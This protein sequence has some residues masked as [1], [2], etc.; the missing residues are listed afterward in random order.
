MRDNSKC[1]PL[2][3]N[4]ACGFDGGECSDTT[5]HSASTLDSHATS[6]VTDSVYEFRKPQAVSILKSTD[7]PVLQSLQQFSETFINQRNG[8]AGDVSLQTHSDTSVTIPTSI[9]CSRSSARIRDTS[10]SPGK[11]GYGV[12]S[13]ACSGL[14]TCSSCGVCGLCSA[15]GCDSS[16][17][18]S[19][20][21]LQGPNWKCA[22]AVPSAANN[23]SLAACIDTSKVQA[24]GSQ[25]TNDQTLSPYVI[26]GIVIAAIVTLAGMVFV[27]VRVTHTRTLANASSN[28]A[29]A[30]SRVVFS[31]AAAGGASPNFSPTFVSPGQARSPPIRQDYA[32][33]AVQFNADSS[34]VPPNQSI[35]SAVR[36]KSIQ[37]FSRNYMPASPYPAALDASAMESNPNFTAVSP[38]PILPFV[39]PQLMRRVDDADTSIE[40]SSLDRESSRRARQVLA[41]L[42]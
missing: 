29:A 27:A 7:S 38:K 20:C 15:T 25:S 4:P 14:A 39:S 35:A 23:F 19:F 36:S 42:A 1:D 40:L 30:V 12:R 22:P 11:S 6:P 8:R 31:Q 32:D 10:I 24:S 2:C 9:S 33:T 5:A 34:G 26:A 18:D 41:D 28:H 21:Q 3:N 13:A 37:Q 17:S 16:A